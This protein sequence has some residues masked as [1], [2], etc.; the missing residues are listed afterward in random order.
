MQPSASSPSEPEFLDIKDVLDI[1]QMQ[2]E[3]FG[4][5]DGIRD[6][7]LLDS[8]LA[9]PKAGFGGEFLHEDLFAMASAYLFHI[10]MNHPFVD[11]NKRTGLMAA[12]VFLDINGFPI[13][14]PNPILETATTNVAAGV[15]GKAEI[16]DLLRT[17]A[18][19][20]S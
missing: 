17:L 20:L 8:A 16:A 7:N 1:H 12:L 9:Q 19:G 18:G 6:L 14:T 4:G 13:E 3:R 10:V 15:L 2:L 11:G 5:S